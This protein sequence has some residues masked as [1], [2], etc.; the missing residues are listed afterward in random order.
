MK[1]DDKKKAALQPPFTME[2]F[3]RLARIS[4]VPDR[5][6]MR[7]YDIAKE[8]YMLGMNDGY[9]AAMKEVGELRGLQS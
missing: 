9:R 2:D 7:L 5:A 1:A 8:A 3:V 4:G 6:A